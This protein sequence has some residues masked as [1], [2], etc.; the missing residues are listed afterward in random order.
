MNHLQDCCHHWH[1]TPGSRKDY[2]VPWGNCILLDDF[3]Q[4][5]LRISNNVAS[6]HPENYSLTINQGQV[7]MPHKHLWG[8]FNG[9]FK[10]NH[11]HDD[12]FRSASYDFQMLMLWILFTGHTSVAYDKWGWKIDHWMTIINLTLIALT[13]TAIHHCRFAWHP[14]DFRVPPECVPARAA[15]C[16]CNAGNI[17]H[18]VDNACTDI[19]GPL[20]AD[21]HLSSLEVQVNKIDSICSMICG[22]SHSTLTDQAMAQP[23]NEQ[24]S[25]D[26]DVFDYVLEELTEQPDNSF[27]CF[28][29][30]VAATEARMT[31]RAVLPM[32]GSAI[33]CSHHPVPCSDSN[34]NCNNI[35]NITSIENMALG[36]GSTIVEGAMSL[37]G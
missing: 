13:T 34:S 11:C 30:L 23:H 14:G 31:F 18:A 9:F 3:N 1:C 16:K 7:Y 22:R 24:G 37:G 26:E 36:D 35:T 4:L 6:R 29:G 10:F 28:S 2:L 12:Q 19:F 33:A 5:Y 20:H 15:L 8:M 21:F 17:T 27:H 32:G 25:G